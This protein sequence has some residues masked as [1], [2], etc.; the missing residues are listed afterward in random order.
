V[1]HVGW[2]VEIPLCSLDYRVDGLGCGRVV[3][4]EGVRVTGSV[5]VMTR[6]E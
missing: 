6:L 1:E 3:A 5:S 4:D 2:K